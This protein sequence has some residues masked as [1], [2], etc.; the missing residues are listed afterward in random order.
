[1]NEEIT[2][3][4]LIEMILKRK[5]LIC[6]ITAAAILLSG[7]YSFFILKP[8]YSASATLLANPIENKQTGITA[9]INEMVDSLAVF[10]DMTIDTYKE[11]VINSTVLT[12]TINELNLTNDSGEAIQ[13]STLAQ[14]LS[15]EK[16]GNT[17]L[18][19]ITV[20]DKDPEMAAKIANSVADKFIKYVSDNTRKF[21][22][23]ATAVIEEQ[24]KNEESKLEE[25][26]KKL[27][28]YLANSQNIDQLKLE[29]QSLY[30]KI[31]SYN[32]QL[33]D[34]EKQIQSDTD[35]LKVLLG[36]KDTFSDV[37]LDDIKLNVPFD[38]SNSNQ[39]LEISVK[40]GNELQDAL[41]TIKATEIETRLV[42]NNAEKSSLEAKIKELEDRLKET[43]SLLAEEE[44]KYNAILRNYDL[45]E[46]TYNAYLDR[47]KEAVLAAT[48]NIG[49]SAIIVS[50]P[51]TVPIVPSNHGKLFYLVIGTFIGLIFGVFVA[52]VVGY[53]KETD[54][55]KR[56][57]F[58]EN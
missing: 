46:Q 42:Q 36:G 7:I 49:E 18:L 11:Q 23:Q 5:W 9:G 56:E 31:D 39:D 27:K 29:V 24:L 30:N 35:A 20:K 6:I 55:R 16:V 22:E 45:A 40:S 38:N 51:A 19:K 1:M 2:L 48:S 21:G 4:E 57:Q 12:N 52:F 53:W 44:Y 26:A 43:Q 41:V 10:P 17:N 8:T 28:E 47:H 33:I 37:N 54:P 14:K 34:T 15:V 58:R 32:M 3:R 50:A 25:E 13:W